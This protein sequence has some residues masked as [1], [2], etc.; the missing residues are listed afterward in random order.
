MNVIEE[1][2]GAIP[3]SCFCNGGLVDIKVVLFE[4]SAFELWRVGRTCISGDKA[5]L[6]LSRWIIVASIISGS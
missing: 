4:V 3:N 5:F 2:T 1:V 6:T